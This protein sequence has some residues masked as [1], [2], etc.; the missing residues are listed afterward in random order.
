VK[1]PGGVQKLGEI[2]QVETKSANMFIIDL[3]S[4]PDYVKPVYDAILKSNMCTNP[5]IEKTSIYIPLAKV[6]REH[7][8][9]MSKTVKLKCEQHV[10]RMHNIEKKNVRKVQDAPKPASNDLIHN[11]AEHV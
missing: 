6:T 7:R 4:T 3:I 9:N 1:V 10:K 5:Q 2:A 8:E 11:T